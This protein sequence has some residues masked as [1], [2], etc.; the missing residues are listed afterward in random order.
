MTGTYCREKMSIIREIPTLNPSLEHL[1]KFS[2]RKSYNAKKIIIHEGDTSNSLYY[3]TEGSVSVLAEGENGEEIIL[4]HL[5]RGDFFGENDE[6]CIK[7][8]GR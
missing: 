4:A 2:H 8:T 6:A 7:G 1:L 3:I 5:N